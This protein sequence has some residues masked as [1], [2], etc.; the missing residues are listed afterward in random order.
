MV[1]SFQRVAVIGSGTMGAAIAAHLANAGIP[2]LLLDIVPKEG[3]DRNAIGKAGLERAIKA[4]PASFMSAARQQLITVGNLEDDIAKLAEVDWVVEAAV[5]NLE[6]KRQLWEKVEQYVS[7]DAIISSNSSG[8]PMHLQIEGRSASFRERFIGAHFFNPPRYLYLL[9]LI[10]TKDTKPEVIEKLRHFGDVILGKGIVIANDVPGFVAN[11]VGVYS[12]AHAV[13]TMVSM[14]LTPDVV[15]A[16]T[17]PL[18]GR[19]KSATFRTADLTGLDVL[20]SVASNLGKTTGENFDIPDVINQM[21]S[22]GLLGEKSKQGF[23]KA[24]KSP[25]GKRKI[26]TLNFTTLQYEDRGKVKLPEIEAIKG[27][28]SAAQRI[29]GLLELDGQIG[30]FIR[31]TTFEML[32]YASSKV[33]IVADSWTEI[34]NGLKWGFGWELGPFEIIDLLGAPQVAATLARHGRDLPPVLKEFAE[35]G[36]KFYP[37]DKPGSLPDFFVVLNNIKKTPQN[38]VKSGAEASLIDIGDG[39]LLMEFHAKMNVLGEDAVKMALAAREIVPTGFAGLVIGNQGENFSAGANLG[40]VAMAA[41]GGQWD[42]LQQAMLNFQNMTCGMRSAPF[43]VVSAPFNL[44]LGGGCEISVWSDAI[45]AHAE[46]YMGLVEVGVGLIPAGGGTTE[47]LIRFTEQL[48][49]EAEPF[50]AVKRA[51]QLIA[52]A[53][54]STSAFEARDL[55]F[56]QSHDGI[57]MN[58]NR[59]IADA[60]KR[61]LTMADAYV[62]PAPR[63]VKVLGEA[64]YANLCMAAWTMAEAK[65]I[66]EYE[67]HLAKTL[68]KILAGGTQNYVMEVPESYLL[69][70]ER[71]AFLSL[72][73]EKKTQERIMHT[74]TTG[75]PLRN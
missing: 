47:M 56:L 3:T 70:L 27:K 59:V 15:D 54:T 13:R 31:N 72:C 4:R 6:I 67:L 32:W 37:D 46:L 49:P 58:R 57:T 74:L 43:P 33:G 36:K 44:A 40:M 21:V 24:E 39:V 71:E 64:A 65:Q 29:V 12:L 51:F 53:K 7:P 9:E 42:L 60:K 75:K 26:L 61:V 5:E 20:Q 55:G 45:Q 62:P 34:D 69:E 19:P 22:K 35:K 48:H 66:T 16:L 63:T 38:I 11:R 10:P 2:T 1:H 17:G 18:I 52:L 68:A 23:Y 28:S 73:G 14:G 8:I 50:E 25:D 30:D 41:A